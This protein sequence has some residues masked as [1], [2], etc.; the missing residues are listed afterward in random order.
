M[1]GKLAAEPDGGVSPS[2][3]DGDRAVGVDSEVDGTLG[4]LGLEGPRNVTEDP[5]KLS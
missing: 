1:V 5:A 3:K 2:C 4:G